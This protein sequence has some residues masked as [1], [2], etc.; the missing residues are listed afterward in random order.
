MHHDAAHDLVV[1]G[2]GLAGLAAALTATTGGARPLV[3]DAHPVGGR[4]RTVARDGYLLNVGP[5]AVYRGAAFERLL[6]RFD[7]AC[8]GGE[9]ELHHTV[10][11]RDGVAHPQPLTSLAL[12]RTSLL[13][14]GER[15]QLATLMGR[16]RISDPRR[17]VGTTVAD[18]LRDLPRHVR[19]FVEMLVR[20]ST[21][22]E[23][24]DEF[25]AGAAA[26][27]LRLATG[28]GVR[29]VDGGWGGL[30]GALRDRLVDR[31][32]SVREHAEATAVRV[33][34]DGPVVVLADGT[35]LRASSVVIAA[36]GPDVAARLTGRTAADI[37][38][39]AGLTGPITASVLDLG[40]GRARP[41]ASYALDEPLYLSAHAP[42]AR[43]A[44][45]GAGLVSVMRYHSP[46]RPIADPETVAAQLRTHAWRSGVDPADVVVDRFLHRL[47]VAHGAPTAAAG[48][49]A[50]RPRAD[51]LGLPGVLLAG[52]WVG[53]EGL[54]A[55]A[56]VASGVEAG[57]RAHVPG[58]A[59]IPA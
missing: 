36:G 47:V 11:V 57:R 9:P 42:A 38:G 34:S 20:I 27:Q 12:A 31:G 19:Q 48:G 53:P 44:P 17:L 5:H 46:G 7:V 49:L 39:V 43:L 41:L 54:L 40:L 28:K 6:E 3:L 56:A 35:E 52:D 30:A 21:Y 22:T 18:W 16:L 13:T 32:G 59:R 50:G 45:E 10:L 23:A 15:V 29:Y 25:D 55:D 14:A 2:A 51:A 4:A 26:A 37:P 58:R 24:P 33:G 1:V 8:H